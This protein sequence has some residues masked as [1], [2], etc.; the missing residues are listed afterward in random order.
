MMGTKESLNKSIHAL[1]REPK[2]NQEHTPSSYGAFQTL[3]LQNIFFQY[4]TEKS[5]QES[6]W[7]LRDISLTIQSGTHIGIIGQTGSGKST[8]V[9]IIMGLDAPQMGHILL[10]GHL[11]DAKNMSAW[12]AQIAHVSQEIFL[13][14]RSIAENIAF[15][16]AKENI[17]TRNLERVARQAQIHDFITSL[18]NQYDQM[19]GERGVR[20][21][22]GQIQ[23]I[24]I[25][26]ALYKNPSVLILDE[27]TSAL[28]NQTEKE[29]M[30]AIENLDK[31]ITVILI[32]HRLSTVRKTKEIFMI[33][34][35][36]II[37]QGSYEKL[38]ED[39]LV[40]QELAA[41]L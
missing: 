14:D 33:K 17:D 28:D 5:D 16:I 41:R 15:G 13:M 1:K 38:L 12:Q 25:A 10:N 29:L 7:A 32:A 11:L 18:P 35:G 22:G 27:G 19:V 36:A 37:D 34:D 2:Y 39:S 23:R 30:L 8:L 9:D 4:G 26:R 24:G 3:T 20:L 6:P 31:N 40:F 21:S